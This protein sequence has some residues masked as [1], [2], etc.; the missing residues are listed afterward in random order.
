VD[1]FFAYIGQM[2][3]TTGLYYLNAR[4]Y[5]PNLGLFISPDTIIPNPLEPMDYNRYAYGRGNPVKYSDPSGHNPTN[6]QMLNYPFEVGGGGGGG[7]AGGVALVFIGV[8]AYMVVIDPVTKEWT[9]AFPMNQ[10]HAGD[11]WLPNVA[12]DTPP[13][14]SPPSRPETIGPFQE[15]IPLRPLTLEDY[16]VTAQLPLPG[17]G[18]GSGPYLDRLPDRGGSGPT[19]GILVIDGVE[20]PL[21]SGFSGPASQMLKGAPGFDIITRGHV[22]GHA[23]AIMRQQGAESATLYIN[24]QPCPICDN[25]LEKMLPEGSHLQI[26]GP[27]GFSKLYD[28]LAD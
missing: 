6:T 20:Y 28:G 7:G 1:S 5:D 3:D 11:N 25:Y 21:V 14:G 8:A 12:P 9:E 17:M 10:P 16:I 23:A 18:A 19:A 2:E 15:S 4:Y 27:N 22:E 13:A 24:N 26:I